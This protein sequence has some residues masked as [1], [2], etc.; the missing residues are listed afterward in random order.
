MR[1]T[2]KVT[3]VIGKTATIVNNIDAANSGQAVELAKGSFTYYTL[4]SKEVLPVKSETAF[5]AELT[6]RAKVTSHF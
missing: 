1:N 2:Y 3:I 5:F 6:L 4:L